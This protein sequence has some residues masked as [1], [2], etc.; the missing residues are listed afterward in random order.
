[1]SL[2]LFAR[3]ASPVAACALLGGIPFTSFAQSQTLSPVA[4]TGTREPMPLDRIVGDIAVIDAA[5]IRDSGAD[6]L[7]ELLRREGG[8]QLSRNGGPGQ[9]AGVLLRGTSAAH[10]VVLVDGVRIGSA[11]LGQADLAGLS[12]SQIERIEILRGPASS[13]Y[14]ADAVGGVVQIITRRGQGAPSARAHAAYGTDRSSELDGG[15]AG[16]WG[17]FDL[18]AG[19]SR[20][21][22][23]GVSAIKPGDRFGNFNPDRDG[24]RR[25]SAQL[26]AG[27]TVAPGHRIGASVIDTRLR[28]QFDSAEFAPPTF[29]PD[30]SPDFRNRFDTRVTALDYQGAI[31]PDWTASVQ[32]S[33]QR[34]RLDSGGTTLSRFDTER[35]QLTAQAG[36]TAAPGHRVLG[37]VE[38]LEEIVTAESLGDV[39][40]RFNTAL[41]LGYTGRFGAHELQADVRHDDNSTFG[42]V[43]TGKLGWRV[44]MGAGV[45]LR[46]L[47]GTSFRAPTF[48]DLYYPGFGVTTIRPEHGTSV[49]VGARWQGTDAE[50]SITVYR[51]RLRDMIGFEPDPANCPAGYSFGC[52]ANRSRAR[53]QGATLGASQRVGAFRWHATLDFLDAKDEDT[54]QRLVRRAAHQETVGVEWAQGPWTLGATVLD[55][56][57]R[58]DGGA[59]L[60]GYQTLDM[61]AFYRVS[62]TWRLEA[63]ALNA[64]DRH[65]EPARD[66]QVPGRQWWLG[67]RYDGAGL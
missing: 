32:L 24:Y 2:S 12:L 38:R 54:G 61:L 52:A 20:E 16:T 6:T 29:A 10:T 35:R 57:A 5:R 3:A 14:G 34:D 22:S 1:M 4:V 8:I 19:A 53:L 62:R 63:K 45:S 58:P 25:T 33:Q 51:N 47:A 41:V 36:W 60:A 28:S 23:D 7:E 67:I 11:S 43:D 21:A 13:L 56:G 59:T 65:Y 48:N 39:P 37:A 17:A 46:A 30:P 9:S 42:G 27:V 50:A 66:Y 26:R 49:E 18:S 64:T 44:D 40:K 31:A 55:V 15:V